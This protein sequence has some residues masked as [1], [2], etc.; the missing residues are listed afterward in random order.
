MDLKF[1]ISGTWIP[2]F[3]IY[4]GILESISKIF[5]VFHYHMWGEKGLSGK[6]RARKVTKG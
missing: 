1:L 5:P 2:D 6:E 4:N 3:N